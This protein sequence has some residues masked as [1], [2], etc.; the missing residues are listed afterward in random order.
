MQHPPGAAPSSGPVQSGASKKPRGRGRGPISYIPV[1]PFDPEQ[2]ARD[3]AKQYEDPPDML[4][5]ENPLPKHSAVLK[6][7]M[8]LASLGLEP[9]QRADSG[10]VLSVF[11]FSYR[12]LTSNLRLLILQP[13]AFKVQLG[14]TTPRMTGKWTRQRSR[15]R[16]GVIGTRRT[17]AMATRT[18]ARAGRTGGKTGRTLQKKTKSGLDMTKTGR[19]EARR[20]AAVIGQTTGKRKEIL[21][22]DRM[23]RAGRI[24]GKRGRRRAGRKEASRRKR[25][26]GKGKVG[27]R[28]DLMPTT[29]GIRAL[30]SHGAMTMNGIMIGGRA[31]LAI[32]GRVGTPVA[33]RSG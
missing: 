22:L 29:A 16:H 18:M 24:T 31:D 4:H 17:M 32:G 21:G 25:M 2:A 28:A 5:L 12:F 13:L 33:M 6:L 30:A 26:A 10:P 9:H 14:R 11:Q 8:I 1:G 3:V 7:R 20:A 23:K 15:T 27:I 19:R